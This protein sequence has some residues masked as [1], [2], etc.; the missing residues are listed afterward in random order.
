MKEKKTVEMEEEDK[1]EE[2][3]KITTDV[4]YHLTLFYSKCYLF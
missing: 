3:E 2:E 1:Q 4:S